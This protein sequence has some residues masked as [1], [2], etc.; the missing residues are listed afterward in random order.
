MAKPLQLN[1]IGTISTMPEIITSG[2]LTTDI[3]AISSSTVTLRINT[4]V[5]LGAS[6]V[7]VPNNIRLLFSDNGYINFSSGQSLTI[8]GDLQAGLVKIFNY[9]DSTCQITFT[10]KVKIHPEWWGALGDN[11]TDDTASFQ[12][13]FKSPSELWNGNHVELTTGKRYK[14]SDQLELW[15]SSFAHSQWSIHGH[16][17]QIRVTSLSA[18]K[19]IFQIGNSTNGDYRVHELLID[20]LILYGAVNGVSNT[21]GIRINN[22]SFGKITNCSIAGFY[23]GIEA[24][25]YGGNGW[26]FDNV[27]VSG[28]GVACVNLGPNL[29]MSLG[30]FNTWSWFG[31]KVQGAPYGFNV[32]GATF[33][34]SNVDCSALS[35]S[36]LKG[37]ALSEGKIKLYS[38]SI[39]TDTIPNNGVVIDLNFCANLSIE[40]CR[41]NGAAATAGSGKNSSYGIKLT[42]CR[43][44]NITDNIFTLHQIADI[45]LDSQCDGES[46][47]ISNTNAHEVDV[48][49]D[50]RVKVS[51]NSKRVANKSSNVAFTLNPVVPHVPLVENTIQNPN[52]F[53]NSEWTKTYVTISSSTVLAPD[54]VSR[55]Q[56]LQFPN[57]LTAGDTAHPSSLS[58]SSTHSVGYAMNNRI[59]VFRYWVKPISVLSEVAS[60]PYKLHRFRS[61]IQRESTDLDRW[62]TDGCYDGYDDWVFVERKIAVPN[63][64]SAN[65]S[66][67]YSLRFLPSEAAGDGISVALWG[68]Q[69]FT[70]ENY[71]ASSGFELASR[72]MLSDPGA[73]K[74]LTSGT[75]SRDVLAITDP[76][77]TPA[78]ADALRDDLVAN[79]LPN[80]RNNFATLTRQYNYLKAVL[81]QANIIRKLDPRR[82]T[83]ATLWIDPDKAVDTPTNNSSITYL[84][85]LIGT[86]VGFSGSGSN[87]PIYKTNQINGLG[88]ME[89]TAASSQKLTS[90]YSLGDFISATKDVIFMVL[91]PSSIS[92]D[93]ATSYSNVGAL[94][95]ANNGYRGIYLRSSLKVVSEV[96][97]AGDWK[98]EPSFSALSTPFL[99]TAYHDGTTHKASVNGGTWS[100]TA[101]IGDGTIDGAL[102]GGAWKI[103][104]GQGGY[105]NGQIGEIV[106]LNDV[107]LDTIYLIQE[108][109]MERWGLS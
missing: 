32:M 66:T 101:V 105:F 12:Y 100:S 56:I 3:T 53:S 16:G 92:T 103:G 7:T 60:P 21:A 90:G 6:S 95:D 83:S 63:A 37:Y 48:N 43:N 81:K 33:I 10:Y 20:G 73:I 97:D 26:I 70:V 67:L 2:N 94:V 87:R 50:A 80:V 78:S 58:L 109:L 75:A 52:D 13:M 5:S 107:N 8:G 74:D 69:V 55:A 71:H 39:G 25:G 104:E 54:G 45:Y 61:E 51:D 86:G 31:G 79:T 65:P 64:A 4:M 15:S 98:T 23:N 11:S 14:I 68:V 99:V 46:I 41:I 49:K 22:G 76:A 89:F 85:N 9:A 57:T 17:A 59:L 77:D 44:L 102:G 84:A 35:V 29:N 47:V 40:S 82:I 106:V 27:N 108:Y 36:A 38:E 62:D 18:G 30:S 91:N 24:D 1:A 93:S 28:C 19:S 42:N 96:Y 34:I 88:V 72:P